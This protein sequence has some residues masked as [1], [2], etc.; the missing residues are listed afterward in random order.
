MTPSVTPDT[1][2]DRPAHRRDDYGP[3]TPPAVVTDEHTG[4][5][6]FEHIPD[7]MA[8]RETRTAPLKPP[9]TPARDAAPGVVP[10][11]A[12]QPES[13]EKRGH[14]RT[15]RD[16]HARSSAPQKPRS[17][18]PW[19]HRH[20]KSRRASANADHR[21]RR[22][23]HR[24]PPRTRER[25]RRCSARH[26]SRAVI[27]PPVDRQPS[28]H[29][30]HSAQATEPTPRTS[31]RARPAPRIRAGDAQRAR[32]RDE[33]GALQQ[34]PARGSAA[35]RPAALA[36]GAAAARDE[37]RRTRPAPR[38]DA[39]TTTSPSATRRRPASNR[40]HPRRC[41]RAGRPRPG[42]MPLRAAQTG[43]YGTSR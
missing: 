24:S 31:R 10:N 17:A 9:R 12:I 23:A 2:I 39:R 20:R 34:C 30:R 35:A 41:A 6:Q 11:A 26:R 33:P 14:D 4:P 28:R 43:T 3:R 8:A 13:A 22:A 7:P 25:H 38:R 18:P 16:T 5:D 42:P 32:H 40:P 15:P 29:V 21:Q 19:R 36:H 1:E 37:R 27:R